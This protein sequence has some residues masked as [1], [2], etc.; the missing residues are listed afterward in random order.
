MLEDGDA[1]ELRQ[2]DV[3]DHDIVRLGVP[4]EMAFLAV[5]GGIDGV[6]RVRQGRDQLA[7]EI[8]IILD[9]QGAHGSLPFG[10]RRGQ[11]PRAQGSAKKATL[12]A[13]G[14]TPFSRGIYRGRRQ[15]G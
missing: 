13:R 1:V 14:L 7:I 8:A 11:T 15:F 4:E 10:N 12:M 3:E 5:D 2:A 6:A 9:D